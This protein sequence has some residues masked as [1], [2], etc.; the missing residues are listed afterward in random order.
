MD[1][2]KLQARE[3]LLAALPYFRSSI[4]N[5]Q[6]KKKKLQLGILSVEPNGSGNVE[7]RFD[8]EEFFADIETLIDAPEFTEKDQQ[9]VEA[10]GFLQRMKSSWSK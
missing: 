9:K 2:P 7:M 3:R 5:C 6:K 10:V 4:K 1:D 8:F